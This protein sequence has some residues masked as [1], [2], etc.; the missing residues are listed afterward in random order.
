MAL[1][2]AG[3]ATERKEIPEQYRWDLRDLY[4]DETAWL[5]D[6]SAL[7]AE[8]PRL[9]AWRGRLGESSQAFAQA[10]AQS[11]AAMRR[12]NRLYAYALQL[13]DQDTRVGRSMQMK[14]EASQALTDLQTAT[15]YMRPEILALGRPTIERYLAAEPVLAPYRMYFDDILRAA[16]HTLSASEERILAGATT[17]GE[18]GETVYSV[19]TAA[20]LPYPEITLSSGEKVKLD[21]AAYTRY[22][23]SPDKAERDAV[24]QAFW[25]RYGEFGRTLAATLNAQVQAHDFFRRERKFG[26]SLEASLFD[27]N[28]PKGVYTQ[29]LSDVHANLPTLHR[30]LRLRHKIMG[31]KQ[32]GYQDLYAPIVTNV[33]LRYTPEQA[34]SLTLEAFAPLGKEYVDVLRRAYAERWMDLLPNEGKSQGAYSNTVYGVHPYQLLNFNGGYEDVSTLA[35]ESGHSLHSWLSSK[36][37]PYATHSYST[38]VAEVAS[39]LNESLM[40]RHMLAGAKDDATRLFLLSS[41]LDV[42]RVT[43]FRQTL[44]AEFELWIHESVE[45]GESLT[46]ES[47]SKK[48]LELARTYYGHAQGI[49]RV[50]DI[51]GAEW[52]YIPHF[53]FNFY[54]YQYATSM[55]G[56]MSLSEGIIGEQAR[57]DGSATRNRDAYL[58]LLSAGSSKYPI[59]LLKDAGVDMTTSQPFQAAIREMNRIMDEME[60]IYAAAGSG[61]S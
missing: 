12:A 52:A 44:F 40:F 10:I 11:E 26:S 3:V 56:G 32:L 39:T 29:L 60:R 54:M 37:Q 61:G 22:R 15:A 7:A 42:L 48:Y 34:Q 45:R 55:I 27:Y 51:I 59:E 43:L 19:L 20:E 58:R 49:T 31:L 21:A 4:A 36:H 18:T 16:P 25:T 2:L 28:I 23:A 1:P 14:Q 50:D 9:A 30:Y 6:K 24:F 53:Y 41:Y 33:E 35:H 17:L 8:L 46:G 47:L 57:R 38:F 5:A 13:Y